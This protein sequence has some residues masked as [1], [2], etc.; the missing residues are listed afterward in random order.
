MHE[1]A[2]GFETKGDSLETHRNVEREGLEGG[3]PP[4]KMD[5]F[6][7]KGDA[8][9]AFCKLMKGKGIDDSKGGQEMGSKGG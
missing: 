3:I 1:S 6:E 4:I 7:N 9:R 5:R 8:G 2:Q